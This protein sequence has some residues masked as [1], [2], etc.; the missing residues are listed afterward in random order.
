[1]KHVLLT[2]DDF[3]SCEPFERKTTNLL[4]NQDKSISSIVISKEE[5]TNLI[6]E[7]LTIGYH[8]KYYY[9]LIIGIFSLDTYNLKRYK[10]FKEVQ[11]I[12]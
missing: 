2:S 5:A 1:M 10:T 3:V 4:P 9:A 11:V 7:V 6:I 8:E 12:I